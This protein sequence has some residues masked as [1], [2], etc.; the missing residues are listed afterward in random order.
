[1]VKQINRYIVEKKY[2]GYAIEDREKEDGDLWKVLTVNTGDD[3]IDKKVLSYCLKLL[4]GG[5]LDDAIDDGFKGF[6]KR[7]F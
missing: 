6:L 5:E 1:M 7:L 3:N 2:K 4:D